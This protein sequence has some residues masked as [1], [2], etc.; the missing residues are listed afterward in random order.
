MELTLRLSVD[1]FIYNP[2]VSTSAAGVTTAAAAT[3]I[4]TTITAG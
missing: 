4:A 1:W 2:F 3:T